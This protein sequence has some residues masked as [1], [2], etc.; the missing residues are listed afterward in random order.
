MLRDS[1]LS[2]PE[3]V[4][5]AVIFDCLVQRW[6]PLSKKSASANIQVYT[7]LCYQGDGRS[8][9]VLWGGAT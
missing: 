2:P 7:K 3:P 8:C 9:C 4:A 6:I 1:A 5:T